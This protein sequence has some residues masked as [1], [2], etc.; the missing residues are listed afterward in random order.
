MATSPTVSVLELPRASGVRPVAVT[1]TRA[2]SCCAS[3]AT[4]VAASSRPSSNV[5]RIAVAPLITWLF[6]R[7]SPSAETTNP[8]PLPVAPALP[9]NG[10]LA[11]VSSVTIVTT[12]AAASAATRVATAS[13]PTA[14]SD[15]WAGDGVAAAADA[16]TA[17]VAA[18]PAVPSWSAAK[19]IP[20]ESTAESTAASTTRRALPAR[21]GRSGGFGRS[22]TGAKTG[23]DTCLLYT[24]DAADDL[25]C[26]DLGGRRI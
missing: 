10:L 13:L 3:A 23:G 5:T 15:P 7:M 9:V 2:R 19:V 17:G 16:A 21:D 14:V 1:L 8:E 24:S 18:A 25:L 20:D 4:T 26:V 6:V 11:P 12:E 22:R